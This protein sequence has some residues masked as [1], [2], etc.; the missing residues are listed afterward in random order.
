MYRWRGPQAADYLHGL[1]PQQLQELGSA[2]FMQRSYLLRSIEEL[3][4][5]QEAA[6]SQYQQSATDAV[7]KAIDGGLD[8]TLCSA[9]ADNFARQGF[10]SDR[11]PA[12]AGTLKDTL[13]LDTHETE[14]QSQQG[15]QQAILERDMLLNILICLF[16][17]WKP[18]SRECFQQLMQAMDM[19]VFCSWST[20][21]GAGASQ[22][23]SADLVS[24]LRQV[25]LG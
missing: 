12:A 2:Y 23:R 1:S 9:L 15:K 19:H 21:I 14:Q 11:G 17:E 24:I 10:K 13:V 6:S 8:K 3:L 18:C 22:S 25:L 20:E 7:K 16:S 5:Q 4:L